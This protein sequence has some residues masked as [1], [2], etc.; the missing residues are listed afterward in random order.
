MPTAVSLRLMVLWKSALYCFPL[1]HSTIF[2]LRTSWVTLFRRQNWSKEDSVALN[3][4][5]Q[6][7]GLMFYSIQDGADRDGR[8]ASRKHTFFKCISYMFTQGNLKSYY[9]WPEIT[10]GYKSDFNLPTLR[11]RIGPSRSKSSVWTTTQDKWTYSQK[12]TQNS[13]A[14][15]AA[16][17]SGSVD[18]HIAQRSRV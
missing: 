12:P 1:Y 18:V 9:I 5:K 4:F 2:Y 8:L 16:F 10:I 14:D 15:G 6:P 11:P 17:W 7:S 13:G 3:L